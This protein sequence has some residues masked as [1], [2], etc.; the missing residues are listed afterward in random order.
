MSQAKMI[1]ARI[2][3]ARQCAGLSQPQLA[4]KLGKGQPE[5]SKW[6]RGVN[7]PARD[8]MLKIARALGT[9]MDELMG[10]DLI[11]SGNR[12]TTAASQEVADVSPAATDTETRVRELE[13]ENAR[14]QARL[15]I[16]IETHLLFIE[17]MQGLLT[18]QARKTPAPP[19]KPVSPR[20]R[21]RR[22]AG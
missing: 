15:N 1:G 5:I 8:S 22:G 13:E 11:G 7:A 16:Q 6:E 9:T 14:L 10:S 4:R 2:R 3:A 19:P 18:S 12:G 20:R 21:H 17:Q